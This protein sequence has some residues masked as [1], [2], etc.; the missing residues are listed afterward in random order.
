MLRGPAD[1]ARRAVEEIPSMSIAQSLLPEFD[2]EFATL[3]TTL[4]RVPA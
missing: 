4:E 2:H 1:A 3:R